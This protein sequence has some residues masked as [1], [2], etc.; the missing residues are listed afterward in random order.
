MEEKKYQQLVLLEKKT[1][2]E[3]I[4]ELRFEKP[5]NFEFNPGQFVQFKIPDGEKFVH[6]SY[7][8]SSSPSNPYL[9][10]CIKTVPS[11]KAGV[12]FSQMKVGDM[13]EVSLAKGLFT[14]KDKTV[15]RIFIATGVGLTPFMS[16]LEHSLDGEEIDLL[17]GVR[18]EADI[19]WL[20]RLEK[21]KA[22]NSKFNYRLT[23]SQPSP[24]WNGLKGRV[25]DHIKIDQNAHYYLCGNM[26]MVKEVR[27]IL[28]SNG[29]DTKSIHF[30][31]F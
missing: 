17:F 12:Y 29:L 28:I 19:F 26:D 27:S 20:E 5:A 10:F 22:V 14:P 13:G 8:I 4:H 23:L 18:S 25:T 1:V 24:V 7:S 2:A 30:E 16:M 21:I 6:R 31:I 9:E 15:H 3:N 11:G